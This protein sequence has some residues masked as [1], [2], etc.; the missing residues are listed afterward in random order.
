MT[1]GQWALGVLQ[2]LKELGRPA[3]LICKAETLY[4]EY[5]WGNESFPYFTDEKIILEILKA[6]RLRVHQE[7]ETA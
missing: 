2:T 5:E 4:I 1:S 3:D 7:N 6:R